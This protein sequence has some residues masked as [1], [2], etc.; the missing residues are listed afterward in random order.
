[1]LRAS[2]MVV[3]K[4]LQIEGASLHDMW[5]RRQATKFNGLPYIVQR[6]AEAVYSPEGR[7][8]VQRDIDYY[9]R[10]AKLLHKA[11]RN[12]GLDAVGG[13]HSPYLWFRCPDGLGS[14]EFFDALLA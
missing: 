5:K 11:L 14:W 2:W 4:K 6:A 1:G 3:P 7:E 8:Q 13:E 12:A 10:N 9:L